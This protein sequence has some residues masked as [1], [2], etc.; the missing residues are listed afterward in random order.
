MKKHLIILCLITVA[1]YINPQALAI[2][3]E[4]NV[5][6]QNA[7][8]KTISNNAYIASGLVSTFFGFGIGHAMQGRYGE[9]GWIFTAIDGVAFTGTVVSGV[10]AVG[11]GLGAIFGNQ[12]RS[13]SL[14][15]YFFFGFL[16]LYTGSRIWQII[17]TWALPGN[18]TITENINFSPTLY[19]TNSGELS[20]GFSFQYKF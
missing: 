20:L 18:Y 17:D 4:D 19:T 10:A 1:F 14:S 9:A 11:E 13:S 16:A 5:T 8:Q 12:A 2:T 3:E 6:Q 7:H 15:G